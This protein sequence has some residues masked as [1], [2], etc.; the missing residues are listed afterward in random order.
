MR[1]PPRRS[2]G[3]TI[4][5]IFGGLTALVVL[6]ILGL[7]VLGGT[8][9][10]TGGTRAPTSSGGGNSALSAKEKATNSPLYKTGSLTSVSRHCR[11][12]C[13]PPSPCGSSWTR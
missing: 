6:A 5:G 11:A 3:G 2:A 13:R 8:Q 10:A 4:A 9:S 7:S 12:S 1:P